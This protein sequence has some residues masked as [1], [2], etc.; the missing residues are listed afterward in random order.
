MSIPNIEAARAKFAE[1]VALAYER[2]WHGYGFTEPH[3]T[4]ERALELGRQL[5]QYAFPDNVPLVL[6][7]EFDSSEIQKAIEGYR[8]QIR[9]MVG[10][11]RTTF[12]AEYGDGVSGD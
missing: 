11:H 5:A 1:R 12:K 4:Y 7:M 10:D 6:S 9:R 3:Y 2:T 8:G